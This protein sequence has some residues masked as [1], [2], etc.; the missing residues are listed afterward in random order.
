MNDCG[1][2]KKC[3]PEQQEEIPEPHEFS[4]FQGKVLRVVW[5]VHVTPLAMKSGP[6]QKEGPARTEHSLIFTTAL[7]K[8]CPDGSR[9]A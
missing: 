2:R 8:P 4:E 1:T 3:N 6:P 5:A 7:L 9:L